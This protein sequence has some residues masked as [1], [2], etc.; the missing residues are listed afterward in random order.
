M[1]TLVIELTNQKAYKLIK[2]LEELHLIRVVKKHTKLSFL[3]DKIKT[4]MESEVIDEQ[5]NKLRE[6]WQRDI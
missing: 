5:L 6:E 4:P 1:D 3:R 2:E